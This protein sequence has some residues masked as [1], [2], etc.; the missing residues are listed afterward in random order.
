[1]TFHDFHRME[2]TKLNNHCNGQHRQHGYTPAPRTRYPAAPAGL[3][4]ALLVCTTQA[5][6]GAPARDHRAFDTSI[7]W[8]LCGRISEKPPAGWSPADGCPASRWGNPDHTDYPIRFGF[9]PRVLQTENRYDFHPGIDIPTPSGT[10]VFAVADGIV[11]SV[12][13]DKVDLQHYR[14]GSWGGEC[15]PDGCYH[16]VYNHLTSAVVAEKQVIKKGQLLGYS[17]ASGSGFQHLHFELRDAD[18]SDATS[19]WMHDAVHPLRIL[20]YR[21][22]PAATQVSITAVDASDP[23][24]P[25]VT[26]QI[27]QTGSSD[28]AADKRTFDINQVEIQI[29]DNRSKTQVAQ[30]GLVDDARGYN[31]HPSRLDLDLRQHQYVHKD[32]GSQS[33][34]SFADC[35]FAQQHGT[36]YSS[37]VHSDQTDPTDPVI[38]VFNGIRI[39]PAPMSTN[40]DDYQLVITFEELLGVMDAGDLCVMAHVKDVRGGHSAPPATWNCNFLASQR[41]P[42]RPRRPRPHDA[43]RMVLSPR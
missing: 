35:P 23:M 26:V 39:E 36:T 4:V 10:P 38:S 37:T 19:N 25:R 7:A 15:M 24:N 33:W 22:G 12:T 18:A 34:E 30:P 27:V 2:D 16:T 29:F 1:M 32:G 6:G 41:G 21:A 9:G 3:I 20:P 8:P 40:Y 11:R 14:P 43:L 5:A 31:L 17:G 42:R 13:S 28:P